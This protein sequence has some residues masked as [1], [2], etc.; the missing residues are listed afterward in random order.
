MEE[1]MFLGLRLVQVVSVESFKESFGKDIAEVYG[2]VIDKY[3]KMGLLEYA[4]EG[5]K[6][7]RLTDKGL[8]VSNTVMAE[9][10][11]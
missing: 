2:E 3:Q 6:Y 4:G 7:L 1:F 9:F 5:G 11:L 10:L 8:D